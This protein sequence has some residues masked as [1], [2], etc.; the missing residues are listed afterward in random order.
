MF[1]SFFMFLNFSHANKL[2]LLQSTKPLVVA[3]RGACG[4]RPAHTL[5]AYHVAI[6]Q[7]N[8]QNE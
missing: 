8:R 1:W 2:D 6:Q 5:E 4:V 7:G 3:H